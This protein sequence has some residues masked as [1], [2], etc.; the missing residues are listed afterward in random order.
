MT[1]PTVERRRLTPDLPPQAACTRCKWSVGPGTGTEER[2]EAHVTRTSHP[3]RVW[4]SLSHIFEP[5]E[6]TAAPS[7]GVAIVVHRGVAT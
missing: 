7:A 2:A 3:V 5:A 1:S 4:R 6:T